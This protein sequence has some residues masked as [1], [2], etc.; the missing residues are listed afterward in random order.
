MAAIAMAVPVEKKEN[1]AVL[2][3]RENLFNALTELFKRATLKEGEIHVVDDKGEGPLQD[4]EFGIILV[5]SWDW[6]REGLKHGNTPVGIFTDDKVKKVVL[7]LVKKTIRR[8]ATRQRKDSGGWSCSPQ[9]VSD[10]K[11]D[12]DKATEPKLFFSGEPYTELLDRTGKTATYSANL[13]SVMLTLG[14]L[15]SAAMR[16]DA[17]LAKE[18]PPKAAKGEF[19]DF[20]EWVITLRDAVFYACHAGVQYALNCRVSAKGV[21]QGFTSDPLEAKAGAKAVVD[22]SDRIFYTWTACET[23]RDL[24]D[25]VESTDIANPPKQF[26]ELKRDV[27]EL[28]KSLRESATWLVDA[29]FLEKFGSLKPPAEVEAV[30]KQIADL[31]SQAPRPQQTELVNAT[32]AYVQ[33]VYEIA[34]YA[35]IRSLYPSSLGLDD[36]RKICDRID[37]LVMG[38]IIGS[39]LDGSNHEVLV[40]LLTRLYKLGGGAK[41]EYQDDAYYPLVVRSLSGLL[42]RTLSELAKESRAGAAKLAIEFR[43]IVQGHYK[44]MLKR[45]PKNL[46]DKSL[47]AFNFEGPYRLYAT[48]RTMFALIWYKDFLEAL[49]DFE[50]QGSTDAELE[51]QIS[52]L[53]AATLA[54]SLMDSVGKGIVALAKSLGPVPALPT[55]SAERSFLFSEPNYAA[56]GFRRWLEEFA[57]TFGDAL[58]KSRGLE[59]KITEYVASLKLLHTEINSGKFA[60]KT[61]RSKVNYDSLVEGMKPFLVKGKLL[62]DEEL[63]TLVFIKLLQSPSIWA[64]A[65][66]PISGVTILDGNAVVEAMAAA[67]S[68]VGEITSLKNLY[69]TI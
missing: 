28:G 54:K 21:F 51:E 22:D 67:E 57:R 44:N 30:V 3:I 29:G 16:Y 55:S 61:G 56:N 1:K 17:A 69:D 34:Q 45:R 46:E 6:L 39:G 35:A 25:L 15:V 27:Q 59:A 43:R 60:K 12:D 68:T 7:D 9:G 32:G 2:E 33:S 36:V 52:K 53:L 47:W 4:C 42:L 49:D 24:L 14:F 66:A 64:T 5:L 62:G 19:K 65:S 18:D 50:Q 63:Q 20:P 31:G 37:T 58:K 41:I 8:L 38:D 10:D 26:S 13:D 48:Q 11:D 23:I 40:P